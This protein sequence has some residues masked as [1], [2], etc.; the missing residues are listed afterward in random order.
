MI[1]YQ[2]ALFFT[3]L[4]RENLRCPITKFLITRYPGTKFACHA[5]VRPVFRPGPVHITLENLKMQ[6]HFYG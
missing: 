5:N 4:E 2:Y 3:K 1:D 6:L